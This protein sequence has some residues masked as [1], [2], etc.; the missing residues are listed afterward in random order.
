M[1][2]P[3]NRCFTSFKTAAVISGLGVLALVVAGCETSR[4]SL[5]STDNVTAPVCAIDPPATN[6]IS[7]AAVAVPPAQRA[8]ADFRSERYP[9][10]GRNFTPVDQKVAKLGLVK[11]DDE[12]A[13]NPFVLALAS[14]YP[15]DGSYPYRCKPME[16]DLYN[17][18]TQDLWYKGRVLAKA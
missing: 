12:G 18:V 9:V 14:C 6:G 5:K 4:S 16:Y 8:D 2:S 11:D 10:D 1:P 7:A 15:T 17:G 3:S 13:L